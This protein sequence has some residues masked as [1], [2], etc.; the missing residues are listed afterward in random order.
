MFTYPTQ[1]NLIL[2]VS[3][4]CGILNKLLSPDINEYYG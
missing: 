2:I 1:Y 4:I 3:I